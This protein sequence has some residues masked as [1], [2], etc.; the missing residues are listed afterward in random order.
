MPLVCSPYVPS[1]FENFLL[2]GRNI[3]AD[4][5]EWLTKRLPEGSGLQ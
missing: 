2:E 5:R 4:M 1:R 3:W